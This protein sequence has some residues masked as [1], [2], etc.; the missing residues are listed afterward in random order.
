MTQQNTEKSQA[1]NVH[2]HQEMQVLLQRKTSLH[3]VCTLTH[4]K[5]MTV[6]KTQG[7]TTV[8]EHAP[9]VPSV[10]HAYTSLLQDETSVLSEQ[11][12]HFSLSAGAYQ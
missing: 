4:C 7:S 9:A 10:T 2:I 3:H 1:E 6:H 11:L 12:Q 8:P 5:T